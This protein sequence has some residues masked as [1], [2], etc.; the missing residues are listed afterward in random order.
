MWIVADKIL[1]GSHVGRMMRMLN[2]RVHMAEVYWLMV[3]LLMEEYR[4]VYYNYQLDGRG[5]EAT[6][7]DSSSLIVLA[8]DLQ[9]MRVYPTLSSLSQG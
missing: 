9:T 4:R 1:N 3:G 6:A 5:I 2:G 8:L 7:I